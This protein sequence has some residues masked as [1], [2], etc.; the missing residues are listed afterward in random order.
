MASTPTPTSADDDIELENPDNV[1]EEIRM[2]RTDALRTYLIARGHKNTLKVTRDV[3]II[4]VF[5]A[6]EMGEE[7]TVSGESYSRLVNEQYQEILKTSGLESDPLKDTFSCNSPWLQEGQG[8]K[9]KW[10]P[11]T[12]VVLLDWFSGLSQYKKNKAYAYA[13]RGWMLEI[14][15]NNVS[16]Q[17]ELCVLKGKHRPSQ[18]TRSAPYDVWV[19]LTKA[20]GYI[21][22]AYCT[23]PAG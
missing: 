5:A 12:E 23:C 20:D 18:H 9:T 6:M 16:G 17:S 3:L 13:Q 15:Y 21:R 4:R 1:L 19:A 10:P 7:P 14:Q 2:W 8:G 11:V 22:G